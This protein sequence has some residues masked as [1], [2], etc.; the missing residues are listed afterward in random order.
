MTKRY[1]HRQHLTA[2]T[3]HASERTLKRLASAVLLLTLGLGVATL[4]FANGIATEGLT[5]L[6]T[7]GEIDKLT[8]ENANLQVEVANLTSVTRI[9]NEAITLGLVTPKNAESVGGT[10]PVALR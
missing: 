8:A 3:G 10:N 9:Y 4:A 7:Q 1:L 6:D 2:P 5:Q